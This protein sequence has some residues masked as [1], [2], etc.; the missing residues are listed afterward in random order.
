M[1][2]RPEV[3]VVVHAGGRMPPGLEALADEA[4]LRL[5]GTSAELTAVM[6]TAEVLAVYDFATTLVRECW[7]LA[8]RV[9]W[10]H[11]ASAG[12]DAVLFPETVA[13]DVVVT[14]ARGVFDDAIAEYVLGLVLL[15]AKD[16]HTTVHLQQR[17]TWRHRESEMVAGSRMLVV[18]AGSIGRAIAR[19]ARRAGI[20]VEGIAR[21]ERQGDADFG[22][23]RPSSE[24]RDRLADADVVVIAAPLTDETRR[25]FGREEL[26]AMR[27]GARLVNVGRGA[28]VD[29]EAL[30]EALRSGRLG[31]AALDVFDTEPLPPDDPLWEL[32]NVVVSP[33]MSGDFVGWEETLGTQFVENL[34]R[35]QR[36]QQLLNVVDKQQRRS[37]AGRAP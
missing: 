19:L 36:G 12:V 11:A 8:E 30:V 24:L 21:R 25:M 23:V 32:P 2:D 37:P 16:L 31:G 34:R 22:H 4:D 26:A 35:W 13:A 9:G 7:P 18:G 5:A 20:D 10:I 6:P 33:H 28:I 27:P 15:F 17:R 1:T 29:H 3:A 14:N